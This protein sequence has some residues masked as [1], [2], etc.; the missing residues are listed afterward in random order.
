VPHDGRTLALI[1]RDEHLVERRRV[2]GADDLLFAQEMYDDRAKHLD[3]T[4]QYEQIERG[5]ATASLRTYRLYVSYVKWN[6]VQ[7]DERIFT[8]V[9]ARI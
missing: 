6:A 5:D 4:E 1:F 9:L 7:E 8:V 3:F 2:V